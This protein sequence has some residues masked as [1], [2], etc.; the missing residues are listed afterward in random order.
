MLALWLLLLGWLLYTESGLSWLLSRGVGQTGGTLQVQK[1][2]GNLAQGFELRELLLSLPQQ[3]FRAESLRVQADPWRL[4]RREIRVD[5][6]HLQGGRLRLLPQAA[7][8]TASVAP[9]RL[10]RLELPVGILLRNLELD[11]FELLYGEDG[12]LPFS[13]GLGEFSLIE[14]RLRLAA[15]SLRHGELAV[16]LQGEI[17]T[18]ADWQGEVESMGEWQQP[19]TRHQAELRLAGN[20]EALAVEMSVQGAGLV[21]L[22]ADLTQPLD[23]PGVAASL[24]LRE[25]RPAAFGLDLPVS[26]IDLDWTLR[27]EDGRLKVAGPLRI[28]GRELSLDLAGLQA[29]GGSLA[30]EA[31][32][33][34]SEETGELHVHG[35][36]PV[37]AEG[38]E[39]ELEVELRRAWL[40]GWREAL[41]E[42]PPRFDGRLSLAGRSAAWSLNSEGRFDHPALQGKLDAQLRGDADSVALEALRVATASGEIEA[43][44]RIGLDPVRDFAA[45]LRLAELQPGEWFE[46]W[47][48]RV[49]GELVVAGQLGEGHRRWRIDPLKFGGELRGL[50]LSIDGAAEG[51]GDEGMPTQAHARLRWGDSDIDLS[52]DAEGELQAQLRRVDLAGSG[53]GTGVIAGRLSLPAAVRDVEAAFDGLEAQLLLQGIDLDGLSLRQGAIDKDRGWTARAR[54]EDLGSAGHTL[55]ELRLQLSGEAGAHQ[56]GLQLAGARGDIAAQLEGRLEDEQWSGSL[57]DMGLGAPEAPQYRLQEPVALQFSRSLV[58]LDRACLASGSSRLCLSL[59]HRATVDTAIELEASALPLA[60]LLRLAEVEGIEVSGLLDGGGR[61][62]IDAEGRLDGELSLRV[63]EGQLKAA[64]GLDQP[65][66]FQADIGLDAAAG[67]ADAEIL[68]P[69]HGRLSAAIL[70]LGGTEAEWVLGIALDNL[71]FVDGVSSEVQSV[72]GAVHGELRAPLSEPTALAGRV[73]AKPLSFELPALGLKAEDGRIAVV[74]DGG[75]VLLL[76]GSLAIA[77]GKLEIAGEIGLDAD[78]PLRLRL[79]GDNSGLI[80]LPA[81]RLAGDSQFELE[82]RGE[83]FHLRGGLLLRDGL[84]DLERFAPGVPASEDVVI[85]DGP[86][87]APGPALHAEVSIAFIQQVDLRGFGLEGKLGGGLHVREQPGRPARANGEINAGGVYNAYG[88]KLDIERARLGFANAPVDNPSIDLLAVRRVDRQRVGVQVRGNA[89]R[90]L[91]RLYSDPLLDQSETLSYLV[92]G[93]P[94]MTASG[95]DSEQLGAYA[96]ALETAGGNLV[97]GSLGRKLGLAAGVESFGSSL[98]SVLVVGKYLSPR[99]FLGYGSSLMDS[100]Q[101]FILRYR[102]TENI[103]LEALSGLE[104]KISASWRT[105]R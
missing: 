38:A 17:D 96:G 2:E 46:D 13:L 27:L 41:P 65:L 73:E 16:G 63:A 1:V 102:L 74:A 77:P 79:K 7:D 92:L 98:G 34:G 57:L 43:Q 44:G 84:I 19:D 36:W 25:L 83:E 99:F 9:A 8:A 39:G 4:L 101:L 87:T 86:A 82:R 26:V 21:E 3:T 105:E 61:L 50:P 42:D 10:P 62:G 15:L 12:R 80:D 78:G 56:L 91:V 29:A 64:G 20:A 76:E 52:L 33:I 49:N 31:L 48:G 95:A 60:D 55:K 104:Q 28:D 11:D 53:L 51:S 85:I 70:G 54:L 103:D 71:G 81:V 18:G 23:S 6:L 5:A 14:G 32:R 37:A 58:E 22:A 90:P 30:L 75:R 72:R 59:R 97:A 45:T 24:R 68:L 100:T 66:A 88:Q 47:P 94:L 69:G 89:K 67:S 35:H 40:A 93:R